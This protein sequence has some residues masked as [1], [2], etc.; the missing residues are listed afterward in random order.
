MFEEIVADFLELKKK[1]PEQYEFEVRFGT[2]GLKKFDTNIQIS[3]FYRL[4]KIL[5]M[6]NNNSNNQKIVSI[7]HMY[8]IN[9]DVIRKTI[10]GDNKEFFMTKKS[11]KYHNEYEYD[12]RFS[13]ASEIV[14]KDLKVNDDAKFMI[15]EKERETYYFK[16]GKIDLTKVVERNVNSSEDC[17]T[18]FEVEFEI[19]NK[20]ENTIKEI[21]DIIK[22]ILQ[23]NQDNFHII[24]KSESDAVLLQYKSLVKSNFFVGAQ[25]ETLQKDNLNL[26]YNELYSVTSKLDGERWFM[27][28]SDTNDIYF[29]DSNLKVIKTNLKSDTYNMVIIDG[30]MIRSN[31]VIHF[32]GFDLLCFNNNDVRGNVEYNLMKRIDI[33]KQIVKSIKG[34]KYYKFSCKRYI[35]KNVFIGCEILLN[36]NTKGGC[37]GLV[38]TPINEPYPLVKKW[39]KLLKWKSKE[40]NT[41]D[42]FSI[43]I[44]DME[45]ELYVQTVD[46][47]KKMI[48]VLFDVNLLETSFDIKTELTTFKTSFDNSY[49]D[50]TT[51]EN[52]KTNTVIEYKW[53]YNM[54][55]FIPIKTRW[56]KTINPFKQGNFS[57]VACSIWNNITNPIEIDI[58]FKLKNLN[59]RD[60]IY[61]KQ[62][63]KFHNK[64]KENVY[65]NYTN[66]STSLLELCVGKGGD[67]HKWIYNKIN[68]VCGYDISEKNLLECKDRFNKLNNQKTKGDFY[69]LNLHDKHAHHI[70][71][72][73]IQ[74]NKFNSDMYANVSCQFAIHYFFESQEIFENLIAI[75]DNN[76]QED[77]C[78]MITYMDANYVNKLFNSKGNND[79]VY[80]EHNGNIVYFMK[81]IKSNSKNSHFGNKLQIFLDGNNILNET[82]DEYFVD[83][84]FLINIMKEKGYVCVENEPFHKNSNIKSFD[85]NNFEKTISSL[86]KYMVFKKQ[87]KSIK[88]ENNIN[89]SIKKHIELYQYNDKNSK[90]IEIGDLNLYKI[91]C[92]NDIINIIN[93][94][95][96]KINLPV[97]DSTKELEFD[98]TSVIKT[99]DKYGIKIQI[100]D[101]NNNIEYNDNTL[102]I[103]YYNYNITDNENVIEMF[104]WYIV[105]HKFKIFYKPEKNTFSKLLNVKNLI[106]E[107]Q[108]QSGQIE[109]LESKVDST[110]E[111]TVESKVDSTVESE[112]P[113]STVETTVESK[114]DST[115]E[116]TVES[117]VDSTVESETPESTVETTVETT[118]SKFESKVEIPESK[119]ESKVEIS[120]TTIEKDDLNLNETK[121]SVKKTK[122][123]YIE[124]SDESRNDILNILN[125]K[126][127]IQMLKD[128]IVNINTTYSLNLKLSGVKNELI[129]RLEA[130]LID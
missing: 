63:R 66:N 100:I 97:I 114:V 85:L 112:T 14:V 34:D 28:I 93:C 125:G 61:F 19:N 21:C 65:N 103:Y 123:V 70:I 129:K 47:K 43:K 12:I 11:I 95:Y 8:K 130:L 119:F 52:F 33:I 30:E 76:L 23:I 102:Y 64:I 16:C 3:N 10:C 111:F 120:E 18:K 79:Y 44:N 15:R 1:N 107:Q 96:Y 41:I 88:S 54:K 92:I 35:W 124:I 53:D 81:K 36:E 87:K 84:D 17:V 75:L 89:Y 109:T 51:L 122:S 6:Q 20:K 9:N 31:G 56:D 126:T 38:F 90:Y 37:D 67:M 105:L 73:H 71:K 50:P 46:D 82:S 26:F 48:P 98:I 110:V 59:N 29:I 106:K 25:P 45:W 113:E 7:D 78:F 40:H 115:V 60:D 62:M 57:S 83:S 39:N 5:K 58:L 24:K 27:F 49:I 101:E 80:E 32:I 42:L 13:V 74:K 108:N 55:K 2:F 77:G 128:C 72:N 118:E 69:I 4:K 104:N 116:T 68:Y 86:N 22:F 94:E 99:L 121:K 117:K 91:A 127:T